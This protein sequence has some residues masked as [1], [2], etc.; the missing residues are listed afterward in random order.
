MLVI[1]KAFLDPLYSNGAKYNVCAYTTDWF[2]YVIFYALSETYKVSL[3]TFMC[4]PIYVS[5]L[6]RL[7]VYLISGYN[8]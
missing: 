8:T 1:V 4:L 2:N 7:S 5:L 6:N 3:L